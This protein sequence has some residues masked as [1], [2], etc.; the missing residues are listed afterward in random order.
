MA[1]IANIFNVDLPINKVLIA[2]AGEPH[3]VPL[4]KALVHTGKRGRP[5]HTVNAKRVF[6]VLNKANA[7]FAMSQLRE[8]I[9]A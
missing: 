1:R 8:M 9:Q 7:P 5:A 4:V 6:S 3:T 2:V